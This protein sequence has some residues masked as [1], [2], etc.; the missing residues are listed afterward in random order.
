[1]KYEEEA[2]L[3]DSPIALCKTTFLV[4]LLAGRKALG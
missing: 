1:M 2:G 4:Y 3:T